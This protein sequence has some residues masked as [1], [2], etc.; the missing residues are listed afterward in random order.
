M[1]RRRQNRLFHPSKTEEIKNVERR[2]ER[3]RAKSKK[4]QMKRD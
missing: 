3:T 2:R 1:Y 4:D